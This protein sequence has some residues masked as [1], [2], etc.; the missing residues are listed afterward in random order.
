LGIFLSDICEASGQ[1]IDQN[2]WQQ[3]CR[4]ESQYQWPTIPAPTPAE[5]QMWQQA[6]LQTTLV[7]RNLSLPLPL[8]KWS[9][10]KATKP[11]WFY[12]S[13]ENAL[14][15]R[16]SDVVTRHG[17]VPR[18]SRAQ[19]F[20]AHGEVTQDP[21]PWLNTQLATVRIQGDKVV[22]TGTG[23]FLPSQTPITQ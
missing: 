10:H 3:P 19:A 15:H 4:H 18:R 8:G 1:K 6:I 13:Q 5:W 14:Y 9:A 17:I 7:G 23:N 21:P 22:L 11:G 20:H 16:T 2:S 12:A